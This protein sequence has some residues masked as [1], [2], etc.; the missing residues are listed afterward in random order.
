MTHRT[1]PFAAALLFVACRPA[2][3]PTSVFSNDPR[4][5]S[6]SMLPD[7]PAVISLCVSR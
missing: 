7:S 5:A 4:I 6:R 3:G 2:E 1:I